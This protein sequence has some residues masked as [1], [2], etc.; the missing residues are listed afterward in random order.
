MNADVPAV[1][2]VVDQ[3]NLDAGQIRLSGLIARPAQGPPRATIL[4]LHGGSMRAA[5]FHGHADPSLSLLT[6]GASLGFSV[7]ALDRPGYGA[8]RLAVPTGLDPAAQA[9]VLWRAI[10]THAAGEGLG[11]GLFIV[12]HSFGTKVALYM[13]AHDRGDELLGLDGSGVGIGWHPDMAGKQNT[14]ADDRTFFWGR[15]GDYPPGTFTPGVAPLA[16]FPLA[17]RRE[18][19][20]WPEVFPGVASKVRVPVRY[21]VAEHERFWSDDHDV[22]DRTRAMFSGAPRFDARIQAG[23]GHNISLGWAARTYHLGALAFAEE[24]LLAARPTA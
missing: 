6:L 14:A 24:C 5:Y 3:V 1:A 20:S 7:L 10:D 9:D 21:T 11:G 23:A 13:A 22:L 16:P 19:A 17:E 18:S 8:S 2:P 4:A 12:S 15:E